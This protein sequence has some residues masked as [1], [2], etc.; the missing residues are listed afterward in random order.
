MLH[1]M[2]LDGMEAG[3]VHLSHTSY[4][5]VVAVRLPGGPVW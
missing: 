3:L 2:V 1:C 4:L 5:A